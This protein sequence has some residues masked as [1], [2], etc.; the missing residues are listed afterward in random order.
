MIDCKKSAPFD[1]AGTTKSNYVGDNVVGMNTSLPRVIP[2]IDAKL[3]LNYNKPVYSGV[4]T[5]D[6]GW[7]W[8]N[9]INALPYSNDTQNT[10]G[11]PASFEVQGL[12]FGLNY[13]V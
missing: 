3:G 9:Y 13:T 12:Y 10:P 4:L 5:A 7:L 11:I 2:A 8:V 1:D 6:I